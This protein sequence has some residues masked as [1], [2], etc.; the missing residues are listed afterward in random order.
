MHEAQ[1]LPREFVGRSLR[2]TQPCMIE[3]AEMQYK[4]RSKSFMFHREGRPNLRTGFKPEPVRRL[5]SRP[6]R[7]YRGVS[8]AKSLHTQGR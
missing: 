7:P 1:H 8:E 4:K 5:A 6:I 2:S 3:F